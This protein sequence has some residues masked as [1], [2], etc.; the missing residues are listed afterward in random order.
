M[1]EQPH[2]HGCCC[3]GAVQRKKFNH[4]LTRIN[5]DIL[6]QRAQRAQSWKGI[7]ETAKDVKYTK[8]FL[9]AKRRKTRKKI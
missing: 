3:A 2:G 4:G 6:P 5:T 8:E 7:L 9:A 1:I